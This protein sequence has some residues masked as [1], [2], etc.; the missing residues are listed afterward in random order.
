MNEID[1]GTLPVDVLSS[2]SGISCFEVSNPPLAVL[3]MTYYAV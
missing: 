2:G 1:H 3:L